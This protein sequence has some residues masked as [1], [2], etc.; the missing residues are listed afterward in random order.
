M[1]VSDHIQ[2]SDGDTPVNE[3][4]EQPLESSE[5]E[6]NAEVGN[7]APSETTEKLKMAEPDLQKNYDILE[8]KLVTVQR[9]CVDEDETLPKK[10]HTNDDETDQDPMDDQEKSFN[11][12]PISPAANQT[13][14]NEDCFYPKLEY[15]HDQSSSNP[16]FYMFT[17]CRIKY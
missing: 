6:D 3:R 16:Y 14:E 4:E 5:V 13:D 8:P 17:I 11:F 9:K 15:V 2:P 7:K 10:T 12:K 1:E